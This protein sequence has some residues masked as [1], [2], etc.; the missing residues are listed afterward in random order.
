MGS[1]HSWCTPTSD[2]LQTCIERPQSVW[3][4]ELEWQSSNKSQPREKLY[5]LWRLSPPKIWIFLLFRKFDKT[6]GISFKI[7]CNVLISYP[8]FKFFQ[9]AKFVCSSVLWLGHKSYR[10]TE[11]LKL[12]QYVFQIQQP[13]ELKSSK[14]IGYSYLGIIL[15]KFASHHCLPIFAV[16]NQ[17]TLPYS[18]YSFVDKDTRTNKV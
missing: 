3:I 16:W 12:C 15:V 18:F 8:S 6:W 2:E 1:I 7:E 13:N 5:Q 9:P 11:C 14:L 4:S 17:Y 10:L